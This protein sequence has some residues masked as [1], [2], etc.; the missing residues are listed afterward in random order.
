[1][2]KK[3][4][5]NLESAIIQLL[6]SNQW[7]KRKLDNL[8][9][10]HHGDK[11]FKSITDL[12]ESLGAKALENSDIKHNAILIN[13][14]VTFNET[15]DKNDHEAQKS[16]YEKTRGSWVVAKSKLDNTEIAL[17]EYRGVIRG[18]FGNLK[19]QQ[20]KDNGKTRWRFVGDDVSNDSRYKHY[21][22]KSVAHLKKRG[23]ANPIRYLH[24]IV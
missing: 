22:G 2:T 20:I 8:V 17:S 12:N 21:M 11:G 7:N 18:V 1:M 24:P 6:N 19:W 9:R 4:S 10:G 14:N 15:T 16:I 13:I 5:F 3:E 23:A